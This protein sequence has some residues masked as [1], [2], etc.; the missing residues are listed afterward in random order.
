MNNNSL[1]KN[2]ILTYLYL[3]MESHLHPVWEAA[4]IT[5]N[6]DFHCQMV[7]ITQCKSQT[8]IIPIPM[9]GPVG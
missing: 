2:T 6:N 9:I 7:L 4:Y 5:I 1:N 8:T 3:A